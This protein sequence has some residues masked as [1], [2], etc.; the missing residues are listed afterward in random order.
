ML[1]LLLH[2]RHPRA[3]HL[4]PGRSCRTTEHLLSRPRSSSRLS[5]AAW[6]AWL[7]RR[8][9]RHCPL[10]RAPLRLQPPPLLAPRQQAARRERSLPLLPLLQPSL[11]QTALHAWGPHAQVR[12]LCA[13][14][15][16]QQERAPPSAR[17]GG[18]HVLQGAGRW[19]WLRHCC[20]QRLLRH[21]LLEAHTMLAILQERLPPPQRWRQQQLPPHRPRAGTAAVPLCPGTAYGSVA[22]QLPRLCAQPHLAA[23]PAGFLSALPAAPV[24]A[25]LEG[26]AAAAAAAAALLVPQASLVAAAAAAAAGAAVVRA[27]RQQ[28]QSHH[29][30]ARQHPKRP[31]VRRMGRAGALHS[32]QE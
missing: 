3:G 8:C 18:C 11:Q 26:S 28:G 24:A 22:A 5:A 27:H 23:P 10:M 25:G 31:L 2:R 13:C 12:A 30:K 1:P 14:A 32:A 19:A 21:S 4:P 29:P 15:C 9:R 20:L 16:W 6:A 17:P 7:R